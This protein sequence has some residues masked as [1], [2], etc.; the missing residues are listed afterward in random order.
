VSALL[1]V[2]AV[3]TACLAAYSLAHY[4]CAAVFALTRSPRRGWSEFPDDSVAVLVPARD[5]GQRALRVI[6]SLLAQDHRGSLDVYLLVKDRHDTALP[7][8]QA[9]F[10]EAEL[11]QAVGGVCQVVSTPG[12]TASVVYVGEDSKSHKVNWMASRLGTRYVAILD[13]DHQAR[14]DWVRTSIC[15][16]AEAG[17]R[18]V[19]GR[20]GPI[21]AHGFF[22]LWDSLHQHIGCEL[23]N[24]AFTRLGLSVFFTGT[25]VVMETDLLQA[26]PLS[27][28]ITEDTD[29]SYGLFLAGERIISNPHSGS[30]EETSPDLYSFLARRRR[31]ANGHTQA[32]LRHLPALSSAPIPPAA[33]VQFLFHGT[34]YLVSLVVFLL[35]LTIGVVFVAELSMLS[36]VCAVLSG[37]V[38]SGWIVRS[39][40]TTGRIARLCEL[41][42]VLGWVLPAIVIAMNLTQAALMSDLSRAVLSIPLALQILGLVGFCAPL[43]IL[44]VGLAGFRQLGVGSLLVVVSTY[45]VAFYLDI[46]GVLLGI[47]DHLLGRARWRP[48]HRDV[49]D[50]PTVSADADELLP[51][52]DIKHSWRLRPV[53]TS[54]RR[55]LP[56]GSE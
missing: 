33:R 39:Q 21:S 48:V 47:T 24:A 11:S 2:C 19:Q 6:S 27:S 1:W 31:W 41:G 54:A 20:R 52:S 17:A 42:V 5:E 56:G 30:D 44:V 29:F 9:V 40:G 43:V 14:P 4:L 51:T 13:C 22:Q 16:L 34:H 32:F 7:S 12:R 15:L 50:H 35:H 46:C 18:I 26:H 36:V 49:P 25:T 53:L 3:L 45:V 23:F 8:L 38:F 55:V 28:C 37:A 10:P